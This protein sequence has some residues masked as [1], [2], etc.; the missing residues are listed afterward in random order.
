M[1]QGDDTPLE[2]SERAPSHAEDRDVDSQRERAGPTADAR[3]NRRRAATAGGA[4][5]GAGSR[6][7]Y[8][9]GDDPVIEE[10]APDG[11]AARPRWTPTRV[12]VALFGEEDWEPPA[13]AHP[14][15]ADLFDALGIRDASPELIDARS[16]QL[17]AI[18]V[19]PPVTPPLLPSPDEAVIR[20]HLTDWS[21]AVGDVLDPGPLGQL[22]GWIATTGAPH[23]D[24]PGRDKRCLIARRV[25][26]GTAA[27]F[28]LPRPELTDPHHTA[29]YVQLE[30]HRT[31]PD[32][33]MRRRE[34]SVPSTHTRYIEGITGLAFPD[35]VQAEPAPPTAPPAALAEHWARVLAI[36]PGQTWAP[37]T[38]PPAAAPDPMARFFASAA[39]PRRDPLLNQLLDRGKALYGELYRARVR[40]AACLAAITRATPRSRIRHVARLSIEIASRYDQRTREVFADLD[41]L[42]RGLNF[43]DWPAE[44]C[45][46]VLREAIQKYDEDREDIARCL[47]TA[48][49]MGS[50]QRPLPHPRT[51]RGALHDA[52]S[53]GRI[54]EARRALTPAH[55]IEDVITHALVD[56][57]SP[58]ATDA[59]RLL[60][61]LSPRL[62]SSQQTHLA[63][64]VDLL[65]GAAAL[66][67]GDPTLAQRVAEGALSH[68]VASRLPAGIV[69]ATLLML[70]AAAPEDHE[71]LLLRSARHLR[72]LG[73]EAW[74]DLLLGWTPGA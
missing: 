57:L 28:A 46:S 19:A 74:E 14:E 60:A 61:D 66:R 36:R 34:S 35:G 11:G 69:D 59:W 9:G 18:E 48:T 31:A 7:A 16:A 68:A 42:G 25:A 29:M 67:D 52:L 56:C 24:A 10:D 55:G 63:Y 37:P 62:R 33:A 17:D 12:G 58:D 53:R 1:G 5:D 21:R 44:R 2:R 4:Q 39:Q 6:R 30:T 8:G 43:D 20:H 41:R 27:F 32:R 3:G 54:R 45:A 15:V 50:G 73:D 38:L 13:L 26:L 71:G 47:A 72:R 49:W 23:L 64:V 22:L 65:A 70:D 40:A 51:E